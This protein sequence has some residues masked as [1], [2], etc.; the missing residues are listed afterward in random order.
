MTP[1]SEFDCTFCFTH[2]C[3]RFWGIW[4]VCAKVNR[5]F[6]RQ[7]LYWHKIK[8][9]TSNNT[10]E[11][12]FFFFAVIIFL[13]KIEESYVY[14][15]F[16]LFLSFPLTTSC[17]FCPFILTFSSC[18][19]LSSFRLFFLYKFLFSSCYTPLSFFIHLSFII[20][21]FNVW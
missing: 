6:L 11:T 12:K 9:T 15:V 17:F 3:V 1:I 2:I 19:F 21:S 10:V 5:I 14:F 7:N 18:L 4:T 8:T 16:F 20:N 13:R